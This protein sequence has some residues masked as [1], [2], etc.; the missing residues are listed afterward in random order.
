MSSW[1]TLSRPWRLSGA[2]DSLMIKELLAGLPKIDIDLLMYAFEQDISKV[3]ILKNDKW[4]G[5]NVRELKPRMIVLE[6]AG[7]FTYGEYRCSS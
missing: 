6:E 3:I 7:S 4:I 1:C 5:V 2:G